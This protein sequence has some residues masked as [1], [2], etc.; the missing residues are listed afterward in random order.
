MMEQK[1]KEWIAKQQPFVVYRK[2]GEQTRIGWFQQNDQ[3]QVVSVPDSTCFVF[4]PFKGEEKVVLLKDECELVYDD[5]EII[6]DFSKKPIALENPLTD[7]AFHLQL[8]QAGIDAIH[9]GCF[10]KVVL[11]RKEEVEVFPEDYQIYFNRFLKKYPTA[12][13]YWFYHPKIGI[14]MGAT[15]EQLLKITNGVLQT[16]ALAATQVYAGEEIA[17]TWGE[18]EQQEQQIVTDFIV[19]SIAPFTNQLT[20]TKPYTFKA[21]SLL[22]I[23]TDITAQLTDWDCAYKVTEAL[24]PTP[25]LCGYP[26]EAARTFIVE[27]EGYERAYYGGYLGE[28]NFGGTDAKNCDLFVNLRCMKIEGNKAS[29][30]LGGGINADSVP[31]KEYGETV[32][33]SKTVKSIL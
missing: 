28:W 9:Q 18:K 2:P 32:N 5:S 33:K 13:V 12:F 11:S 27:N 6:V 14:W 30:F 29:L 22:H 16:V 23:K 19:E 10:Q 24:H 7:K 20:L 1:I 25:A 31:E 8:V 17:V 21:G 26:K 3:L 4:A 15:P